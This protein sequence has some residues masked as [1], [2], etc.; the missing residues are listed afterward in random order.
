[1]SLRRLRTRSPLMT[2]SVRKGGARKLRTVVVTLPSGLSFGRHGIRASTGVKIL[3]KHRLRLRT[4]SGK[5][6]VHVT[7]L[8]KGGGLRVTPALRR[9]VRKHPRVL[10]KLRITNA[11]GSAA[12]LRKRVRLR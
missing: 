8:A 4:R 11:G 5:G 1:V 3:G 9:R 7:A 2:L 10:V 12:T 6:A